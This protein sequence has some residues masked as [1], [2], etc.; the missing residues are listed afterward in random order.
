[1]KL[2]NLAV[3]E[4]AADRLAGSTPVTD[5]IGPLGCYFSG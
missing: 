2:E 1:M 3:L 5:T 4:T